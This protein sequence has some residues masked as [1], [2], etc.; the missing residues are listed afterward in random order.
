M[1]A[2][3]ENLITIW[4]LG[5]ILLKGPIYMCQNRM[6]KTIESWKKKM[7]LTCIWC[8]NQEKEYEIPP[9]K[10]FVPTMIFA[11]R[12]FFFCLSHNG[13]LKV[14]KNYMCSGWKSLVLLQMFL[15]NSY[16]L[17]S[18]LLENILHFLGDLWFWLFVLKS[19]VITCRS[20]SSITRACTVLWMNIK[21]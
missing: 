21:W 20:V 14:L 2:V 9:K 19:N 6:L 13:L 1:G 17:F 12:D 4:W 11:V 8:C 5:A 7:T 18:F 15:F 10:Q 3:A 16:V